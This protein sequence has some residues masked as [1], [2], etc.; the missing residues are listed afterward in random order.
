MLDSLVRVSRR[1]GWMT[2]LLHRDAVLADTRHS[3]DRLHAS[4]F[5]HESMRTRRQHSPELGKL[6]CNPK[7]RSYAIRSDK[8]LAG[9][10]HLPRPEST[11]LPASNVRHH[12][13]RSMSNWS[14]RQ[15]DTQG[16][17][18]LT[19]SSHSRPPVLRKPAYRHSRRVR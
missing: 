6:H 18:P 12:R 5:N 11:G 14:R 19:A 8:L 7:L 16:N 15:R 2:D 4:D 10:Q 13:S 17:A 3:L 1:V 9:I